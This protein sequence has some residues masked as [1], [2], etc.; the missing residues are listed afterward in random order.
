LTSSFLFS[1]LEQIISPISINTKWKQHG[2]TVAGGNRQ[3]NQSNQLY[4]PRDIYVDDDN[5][6][7]YIVDS[8]NHRIVEWKWGAKMGQI[9]AGG[10]GKGNRRNQL[11]EPRNVIVDKKTD[12]LIIC[13]RGNR[14]V[15]RWS[16]RN[17][18]YDQTIISNIDCSGLTM[19]NNGDLYVSDA[20][21]NEVRRWK[22]GEKK[23]TPV[24]GGN[25]RGNQLYQLNY[26]TYLFVDDDHSVYVSDSHNHRVMKWMKGV[27]EG[28]VVA[29]GQGE[30]NC[31][32]QLDHP[33][34]VIVDHLDNIYIADWW[35]HRI[36]CWSKGSKQG[37]VIVGGNGEGK[38][39]NQ[40]SYPIDVSFDQQGHL[41][42]IDSD[43]QRVQKF[44]IDSN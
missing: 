41:Y 3:G 15:V 20:E 25:G 44:E 35:N 22:I 9:V 24:A 30:G 4:Y 33:Q 31:S 19:D 42:V 21:E 12:S 28:M 8:G 10:N 26:P 27:K 1:F 23:G 5:Q 13:D 32:T 43:N 37:R 40:L 34:G 7:I 11:N 17:G 6:C 16:R 14:R 29:G 39:P 2:V 38:Q 18:T 36:V